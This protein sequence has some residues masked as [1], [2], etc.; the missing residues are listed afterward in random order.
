M[1]LLFA[2]GSVVAMGLPDPHRAVRARRRAS[3]SCNIVAVG[4]RRSARS[5]PT[6]AT[7]I[8]LGVGIDYSLFIVTRYRENLADGHDDRGRGR[9]LG[10]DRRLGGAVRRHARS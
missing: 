5:R 2:F 3:R 9:P 10:R 6:L 1:I 7:M 8:G 4:H